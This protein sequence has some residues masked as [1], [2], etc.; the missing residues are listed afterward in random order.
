M[1]VKAS[2]SE[3]KIQI[4][5]YYQGLYERMRYDSHKPFKEILGT[6]IELITPLEGEIT[7]RRVQAYH[8]PKP[9]YYHRERCR[10]ILRYANLYAAVPGGYIRHRDIAMHGY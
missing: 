7:K 5:R 10:L 4:T 3:E 1:F 2:D 9:Y 6:M 8:H